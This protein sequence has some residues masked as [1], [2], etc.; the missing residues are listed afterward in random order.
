MSSKIRRATIEDL[1]RL[2]PLAR[3][4][5]ASSEFL[6]NFDLDR[7]RATWSRLFVDGLGMIFLLEDAGAIVGTLGA[8]MY[9]E[10]YSG[11]LIAS[12][13]F[14]FVSAAARGGR[15]G[16]Q[17]LQAF[18]A[19]ARNRG[20]LEIR[21]VHLLDSMPEKLER[22]YKHFGYRPAEVHYTKRIL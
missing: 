1:D 4:F 15:G 14:W 3:E 18:E 16:L 21:M 2:E 11:D 5:Y 6:R 20:A 7:F 19:W 9:W 10:P 17:L 22:I 12:E 8:V 13:M